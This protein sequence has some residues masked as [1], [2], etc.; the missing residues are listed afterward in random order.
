MSRVHQAPLQASLQPRNYL[1]AVL[2]RKRLFLA[3]FFGVFLPCCL[4]IRSMPKSYIAQMKLLVKNERQDLIISA[5]RNTNS[6]QSPE[7][8]ES[9]VNSEIELLRSNDVLRR[10]AIASGLSRPEPGTVQ[11]AGQVSPVSLDRALED[12][13][14]DLSV[15]PVRKS[16]V[17]ELAYTS[18]NPR[19]A[20]TVLRN[21]SEVYLQAHLAVHGTP[22]SYAFFEQ[23]ANAYRDRLTASEQDLKAFQQAYSSVLLPDQDRAFSTQ[24]MNS[25]AALEQ[26]EAQVADYSN[27]MSRDTQLLATL[28][29]RVV[30]SMRTV[31]QAQLVGNLKSDISRITQQ[32][33]RT[34]YQVP[35]GTTAWSSK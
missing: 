12:L 8:S 7:P 23:Q 15:S 28:E 25:K 1:P 17:I 33:H 3:I 14:R 6:V 26:T 16:S 18:G 9:E 32:A 30:T 31:P 5:D 4:Y 21:L 35:P 22:G 19:L 27:R 10:V 11:A 24:F 13:Q 2:K 20:S 34:A 29:P